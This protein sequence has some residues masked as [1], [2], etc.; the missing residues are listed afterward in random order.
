[1]TCD[2][3]AGYSCVCPACSEPDRCSSCGADEDLWERATDAILCV[4]C[5]RDDDRCCVN[6]KDYAEHDGL[7]LAC[8]DARDDAA[9]AERWRSPARARR[10]SARPRHAAAV[11]L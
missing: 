4:D 10:R 8:L 1:M 3:C 5:A 6:C 9:A 2:A 11:S 7:C